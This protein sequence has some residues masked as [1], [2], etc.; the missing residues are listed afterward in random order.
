MRTRRVGVT[1]KAPAVTRRTRKTRTR[2]RRTNKSRWA[3]RVMM[4]T[5]TELITHDVLESG[6]PDHR[7]P[8]DSWKYPNVSPRCLSFEIISLFA[9]QWGQCGPYGAMLPAGRPDK[10]RAM[11]CMPRDSA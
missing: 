9:S 10:P 7:P 11:W 8:Y 4:M 1:R 5:R 3:M 2:R 6:R